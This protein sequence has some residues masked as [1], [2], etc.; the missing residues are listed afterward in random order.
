MD[1]SHWRW[2]VWV[3]SHQ[4]NHLWRGWDWRKD[5]VGQRFYTKDPGNEKWSCWCWLALSLAQVDIANKFRGFLFHEHIMFSSCFRQT[6]L[7][8]MTVL[9]W[10][11]LKSCLKYLQPLAPYFLLFFHFLWEKYFVLSIYALA[12]FQQLKH[13]VNLE[14]LVKSWEL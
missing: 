6:Y 2:P 11:W 14:T 1:Y 12:T 13:N 10:K 9:K 5:W 7:L 8:M 4:N 3:K